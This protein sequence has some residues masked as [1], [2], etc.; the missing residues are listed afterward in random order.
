MNPGRFVFPFAFVWLSACTWVEPTKE[1][2]EVGLVDASKVE[3]CTRVGTAN[4]SVKHQVGV[5]TRSE[6]KV[7]DELITLAKNKA[8][9]MGGDSIV[10]RD[11]PSEGSMSF[12]VYRCRDE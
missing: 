12:D 9:E 2:S 6:E 10:A 8:A 11:E 7:K 3:S 4:S 5:F 1:G